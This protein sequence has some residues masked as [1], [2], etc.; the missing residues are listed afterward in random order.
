MNII[1]Y[2]YDADYH[3]IDCTTKTYHYSRQSW[4]EW[5]FDIEHPASDVNGIHVDQQDTEGNLVHPL[6]STDEW[7]ELDESYL[8]ENPTQWLACG[9]CHEII[10]EYTHE[11]KI[12]VK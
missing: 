7:Q 11:H 5:P 6:F 9:D 10:E 1:A 2:T 8:S 12:G 4:I 3:C